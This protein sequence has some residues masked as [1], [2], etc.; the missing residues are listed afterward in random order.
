[1]RSARAQGVWVSTGVLLASLW[2]FTA[3]APGAVHPAGQGTFTGGAQGWGVQ[4]EKCELLGTVE[5]GLLCSASGGYAPDQ[6]NPPGSLALNV[7]V[8]VNLLTGFKA[9]AVFESPDFAVAKGGSATLH[10]DRQFDPEGLLAL[11]PAGDYSVSLVDRSAGGE[12]IVLEETLGEGAESFAGKDA[13]VNVKAG[14]TYAIRVVTEVASTAKVA[15]LSGGGSLRFDNVRLTEGAGTD[16]PAN[17]NGPG[18][19]GGDDSRSS[20][21]TGTSS[22]VDSSRLLALFRSQPAGSAVLRGNRLFV[23][24]SCPA[25]VGRAC[26]ITAQGL[27]SRRKPATAKRTVKVGKGRG[28]QVALRVRPKQLD[29]VKKRRRLLVREKVRSGKARATVQKSRVLIRR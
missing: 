8:V 16:G 2:L 3:A 17:P 27:L 21:R 12:A 29:R 6:G 14:H 23:K 26:S 9:S 7:S 18:G 22:N 28:R 1:M 20:S 4:E 11:E 15:L 25:K 5:I 13:V 10:L 24:V 19:P